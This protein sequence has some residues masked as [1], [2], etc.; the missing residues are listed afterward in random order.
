ML[1]CHAFRIKS[2]IK[3]KHVEMRP[4]SGINRY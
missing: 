4:A 2:S 3:V 1:Q